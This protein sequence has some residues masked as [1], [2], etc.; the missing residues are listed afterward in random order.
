MG[1]PVQPSCPSRVTYSRPHRT[2]SRRVLNI[3]REG[4]STNICVHK[5]LRTTAERNAGHG[6]K[7]QQRP[8]SPRR[9]AP[10]LPALRWELWG[11]R[12]LLLLPGAGCQVLCRIRPQEPSW[13]TAAQVSYGIRGGYGL[14]EGQVASQCIP[15]SSRKDKGSHGIWQLKHSRYRKQTLQLLQ[16]SEGLSGSCGRGIRGNCP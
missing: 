12:V 11:G 2:L 7:L 4:D 6:A 5:Q 8:F 16:M 10:S 3:S 14:R 1:H 15:S 13:R 9:P